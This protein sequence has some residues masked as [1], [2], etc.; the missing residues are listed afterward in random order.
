MLRGWLAISLL[1]PLRWRCLV[2]ASALGPLSKPRP[3]AWPCRRR[4]M[5]AQPLPP[6]E[7]SC[8]CTSAHSQLMGLTSQ[9]RA[10]PSDFPSACDRCASAAVGHPLGDLIDRLGL[11]KQSESRF[12]AC[13]GF[14]VRQLGLSNMFLAFTSPL[15]PRRVSCRI[16]RDKT[17]FC[18]GGYNKVFIHGMGGCAEAAFFPP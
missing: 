12:A 5:P 7:H 17:E 6:T 14:R 15:G 13:C 4:R 9:K 11:L 16:S 2:C 1:R 10:G 8:S 18:V 3:W